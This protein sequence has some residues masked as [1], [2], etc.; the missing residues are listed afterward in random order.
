MNDTNTTYVPHPRDVVVT[1]HLDGKD[2]VV[3]RIKMPRSGEKGWYIAV[4]SAQAFDSRML[5]RN[6]GETAKEKRRMAERKVPWPE[7]RWFSFDFSFYYD[8]IM[9]I[10]ERIHGPQGVPL[11]IHESIW[12]FYKYIKFDHKKN[13]FYS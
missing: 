9:T 1:E 8:G 7:G 12:D 6:F 11:V 4:V 10:W 5:E 13:K 2:V 3:H